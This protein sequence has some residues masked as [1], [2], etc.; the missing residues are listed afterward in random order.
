MHVPVDR[1]KRT[2]RSWYRGD[3]FI[4]LGF[5]YQLGMIRLYSSCEL[6]VCRFLTILSI[7][8]LV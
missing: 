5:L 3:S 8:D 1:R 4:N 6:V 7:T 2:E